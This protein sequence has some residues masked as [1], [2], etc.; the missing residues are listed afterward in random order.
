MFLSTHTQ[1][2]GPGWVSEDAPAIALKEST[3]TQEWKDV[4]GLPLSHDACDCQPSQ[5]LLAT[6]SNLA[7]Y[8]TMRQNPANF[9]ALVSHRNLS[10][11]VVN[12]QTLIPKSNFFKK[13]NMKSLL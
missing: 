4:K 7:H 8:G 13:V 12:N 3:F 10:P 9:K 2:A 11:T 6:I 5:G 1:S